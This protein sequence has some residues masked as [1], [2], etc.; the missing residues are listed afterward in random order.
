MDLKVLKARHQE[1]ES[2]IQKSFQNYVPDI[3]IQRYKKEK[4]RI[5]QLLEKENK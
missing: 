2:I 3:I 4:L 5:K 1:L